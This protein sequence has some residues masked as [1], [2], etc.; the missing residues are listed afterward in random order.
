MIKLKLINKKELKFLN[1]WIKDINN[2]TV[3]DS[4]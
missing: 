3:S 4:I 2:I 1:A